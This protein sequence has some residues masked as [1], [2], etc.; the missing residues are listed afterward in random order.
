M[1]RTSKRSI[2]HT[3][4]NADSD[5]EAV[6]DTNMKVKKIRK[7]V[8]HSDDKEDQEV[9]TQLSGKKMKRSKKSSTVKSK[10]SFKKQKKELTGSDEEMFAAADNDSDGTSKEESS[11][12]K[13]DFESGQILRVYC[14]N[15]MCHRKFTV[16][17]GRHLNYV[18]GRNGSGN[19][20]SK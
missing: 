20:F 9:D 1:S 8:S 13:A 5:E 4:E 15:F 14:E 18:N 16:D 10:K 17:F 2:R 7:G 6:A 19:G 3:Q 11:D 12:E